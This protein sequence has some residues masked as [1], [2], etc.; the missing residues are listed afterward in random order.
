M[1]VKHKLIFQV[2]GTNSFLADTG[3]LTLMEG[4]KRLLTSTAFSGGLKSPAASAPIP[5]ETYRIRLAMRQVVASYPTTGDTAEAMH[6]WYGIEKVDAPEWQYEWGH[7][8]AALNERDAKMAQAYRGNFLH[9]KLRV[10]DYTHGCICERSEVI[11]EKL[12]LMK[13]ETV[14]VEVVR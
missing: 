6:H 10:D 1:P 3:T 14:T 11:L 12:W 4:D 8:R 13:P 9:G 7:Y 2:T 5:T